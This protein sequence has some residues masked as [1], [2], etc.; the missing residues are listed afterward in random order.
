LQK[1]IL[2]SGVNPKGDV[3]EGVRIAFG[4]LQDEPNQIRRDLSSLP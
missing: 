4:T 3:P 2:P 1:N